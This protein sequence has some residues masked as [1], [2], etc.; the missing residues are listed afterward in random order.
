MGFCG[1]P[2][3]FSLSENILIFTLTIPRLLLSK[4]KAFISPFTRYKTFVSLLKELLSGVAFFT[5]KRW[6]LYITSLCSSVSSCKWAGLS[7]WINSLFP[8]FSSQPLIIPDCPLSPIISHAE[9]SHFPDRRL[10]IAT[11]TSRTATLHQARGLR[12][13]GVADG[14]SPRV[15][16]N[17]R[18]IK[19]CYPQSS[20]P[21]SLPHSCCSRLLPNGFLSLWLTSY[22]EKKSFY[23]FSSARGCDNF[24]MGSFI[25]WK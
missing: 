22:R 2:H 5:A 8:H 7:H 11:L 3:I 10:P 1:K 9:G 20:L 15:L 23:S 4:P 17:Y 13:S 16:P 24:L 14:F 19:G 25:N 6:Y 12:V 18:F 21:R